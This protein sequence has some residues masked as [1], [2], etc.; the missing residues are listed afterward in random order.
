MVVG[1]DAHSSIVNTLRLL[2][3]DGL[4]VETHHRLTAEAVTPHS[5]RSDVSDVAAVVAPQERPTVGSST[6][7]L[8]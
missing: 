7:L 2:E 5:R 6:I 3:M 4:V 8:E 1:T